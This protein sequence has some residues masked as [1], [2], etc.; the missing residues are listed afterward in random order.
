[1]K[2]LKLILS[3][4][5]PHK[6]TIF[7]GVCCLIVVD[8]IQMIVPKIIQHIIDFLRL[9]GF[10]IS[11]I[12]K[13][14]LLIFMLAII[15]ATLRFLWRLFLITNAYKIERKIRNEYYDH[16]QKLSIRFFQKHKT[17]DLMAYATND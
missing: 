12:F 17:G 15:M 9:P 4:L 11:G 13:F 6:K 14:S 7:W 8:G 2:N 5:K 1:M 3:Y 16:L 10:T